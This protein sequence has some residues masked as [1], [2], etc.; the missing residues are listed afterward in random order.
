MELSPEV[1]LQASV[2]LDQM[3]QKG[4]SFLESKRR[5]VLQISEGYGSM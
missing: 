2:L 1:F 3:T 4:D 5:V